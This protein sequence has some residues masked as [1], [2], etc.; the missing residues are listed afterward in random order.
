METLA[1]WAGYL[2]IAGGAL[3][4]VMLVL[5][6]ITDAATS[7]AWNLLWVV[8]A[9]LGAGV[10]GLYERTKSAVGQLGRV[11]AWVSAFGALGLL[12][13][14]AYAIATDQLD[15]DQNAPNPLWPLWIVTFSAWLVGNIGFTVALIRA[16]SLSSLGAWLV[17]AGAVIGLAASLLGGE[18]PPAALLLVFVLFGVGWIVL[19]YAATRQ[20]ADQRRAGS[21]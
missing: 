7:P 11:S 13:V 4:V 17:V 16:R 15:T 21:R 9:L 14:A 20:E 2:A 6:V 19:G 3:F 8:V 5:V 12:L 18:N 1:R 10:P